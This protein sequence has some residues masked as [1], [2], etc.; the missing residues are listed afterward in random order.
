[1]AA[2]YLKR[3]A[4]QRI[5]RTWHGRKITGIEFQ[6]THAPVPKAAW[7]GAG[8]NEPTRYQLIDWWP[9]AEADYRGLL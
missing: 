5:G 3:I 8:V 1:M 7:M 2:E 6:G 4:L 9:V